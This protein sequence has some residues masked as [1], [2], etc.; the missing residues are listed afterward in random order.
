M[1]ADSVVLLLIITRRTAVVK[2]KAAYFCNFAVH[3]YVHWRTA[4]FLLMQ[5]GG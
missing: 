2:L 5:K 3:L 4:R 1:Q